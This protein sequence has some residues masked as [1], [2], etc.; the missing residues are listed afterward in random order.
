MLWPLHRQSKKDNEWTFTIKT[1]DITASAGVAVTQTVS[2]V[3]VTGTLKTGLTGA[4][5]NSIVVTAT[6]KSLPFHLILILLFLCCV[7]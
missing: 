7:H 6:T 3:V 2:D 5:T 1:Q 4:D